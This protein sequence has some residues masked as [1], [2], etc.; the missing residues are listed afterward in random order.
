MV[1][2]NQTNANDA[3]VALTLKVESKQVTA[4]MSSIPDDALQS[5][6]ARNLLID[7]SP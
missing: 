4:A 1:A 3:T 6:I 5:P 7:C 2:R